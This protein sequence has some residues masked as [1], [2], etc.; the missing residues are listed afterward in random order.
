MVMCKV[1]IALGVVIGALCFTVNVSADFPGNPALV[2]EVEPVCGICGGSSIGLTACPSYVP[3]C[4]PANVPAALVDCWSCAA[5]AG[6]VLSSDVLEF[7]RVDVGSSSILTLGITGRGLG[8]LEGT[9]RVTGPGSDSFTVCPGSLRLSGDEEKM[10]TV[11]FHPRTAGDYAVTL[12]I[13]TDDGSAVVQLRGT[14]VAGDV[15]PFSRRYERR[16]TLYVSG[17]AWGPP[18]TWNPFQ[19]GSLANTTGTLGLCYETLHNYDPLADVRIPW[20]AES[21]EWVDANTYDLT[22]RRGI[23]WSDGRPLT[24]DDVV[25]TFE[26]GKQYAALWF[27]PMWEYLDS[28]VQLDEYRVRFDFTN[29]LYQEFGDNLCNIPIVPRHLWEGRTEED[30][31]IGANENPVGSGAYL[32][33]S[34]DSDR[35][36]WVRNESWWAIDAL[37]LYPGPKRIV[38]TRFPSNS[39]A[40]ASLLNGDLDL[41][42]HF[43]PSAAPLI[44]S[45]CGLSTYFEEAPWML[46]ANT[47]VL[48]LNTTIAPMDD[49]AFRKALAYAINVDDIATRA[50][51]NLV[52]AASPTG[53]L[54]H[55]SA[56]V[57]DAAVADLGWT[58]D[59]AEAR[60]ILAAA[61][62]VDVDGDGFVEAP[63][64][65]TIALEVTSPYGW[66]DWVAAIA[67]ISDSCKAAGINVE[68]VTP[69]YG[70][71]NTQMQ[72]GTFHMTLNSWAAMSNTPWTLYDLLFRHPI[73]AQMQS[74]NFG[75]YENQA[76]FDLVD[77][78]ARVPT[79]D[80]EEMQ[81]ICSQVQTIM[82]TEVPMIPLWYDG[83]RAQWN[84]AVWTNWPTETSNTPSRLPTTWSGYW[85]L[86]GLMMLC[87]LEPAE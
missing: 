7:D 35:N 45:Q 25:F 19:P 67:A 8:S 71:W 31:G 43:L 82:L 11:A 32:Y 62:Y 9:I 80:R 53:L 66:T 40:L 84:D 2:I 29:P 48:F 17:A 3:P 78:L 51:A 79:S 87:E 86:G 26:L 30:I 42:N 77:D 81:H 50:Y 22:V 23:T 47:A 52:Q 16:E 4:R 44:E 69:D 57:D 15:T 27:S 54:P 20:L 85:Q 64:G 37:G 21:G 38:D 76:L 39:V 75:R 33:E 14:G 46:S 24:S 13:E 34:H 12:E 10:L 1:P 58:Y 18:Y 6:I 55:L 83:L 36:V 63:D 49:A 5:Q 72:T 74:G 65:S 61:G 68:D 70:A 56:Y 41:S 73:Q 28:V 60:R 59:P